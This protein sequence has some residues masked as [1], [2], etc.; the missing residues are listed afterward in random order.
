[1]LRQEYGV[2]FS[3]RVLLTGPCGQFF[4][5]DAFFGEIGVDLCDGEFDFTATG[6][7]FYPISN[8]TQDVGSNADSQFVQPFIR[9]NALS[10]FNPASVTLGSSSVITGTYS[11][12][13]SF[14]GNVDQEWGYEL[15]SG[16]APVNISICDPVTTLNVPGNATRDILVHTRR[17]SNFHPSA[18]PSGSSSEWIQHDAC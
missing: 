6:V 3:V 4:E 1:M 12:S 17:H 9:I 18:Y 16:S 2:R 13:R 11:T 15:V 10:S 8:M 7:Q 14:R 5:S